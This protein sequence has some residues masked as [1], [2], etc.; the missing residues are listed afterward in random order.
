MPVLGCSWRTIHN[1][2]SHFLLSIIIFTAVLFLSF[3]YFKKEITYRESQII[4]IAQLVNW[5]FIFNSWAGISSKIKSEANFS[6]SLCDIWN[7][8]FESGWIPGKMNKMRKNAT[9][10]SMVWA[11]ILSKIYFVS[12]RSYQIRFYYMIFCCCN[13]RKFNLVAK[14]LSSKL[15]VIQVSNLPRTIEKNLSP[16]QDLGTLLW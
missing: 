4:G 12:Y 9:S 10:A 7:V 11:A 16:K 14:Y 8:V 5:L 6:S 2:N 3:I 1:P 13:L 15:F